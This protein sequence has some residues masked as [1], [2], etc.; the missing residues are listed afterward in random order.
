VTSLSIMR[1]IAEP[2][3]RVSGEIL[4][5]GE[6]LLK[7]NDAEIRRVRGNAIGMIYQE[8]MAALNPVL[9]IGLQIAEA[10]ELHRGASRGVA[11][12]RAAEMLRLVGISSP[13]TRLN[14]YPHQLSG[15]MRQRVMIAMALACDP[16]LLIADEPT[17]ALDVTIQAQIL[18]LIRKLRHELG[19][20]VMLITH[21]L[22]IVAEMC[23]R[24][25]VMYAGRIVEEGDVLSI[26][27]NPVHP[28][29]AALLASMPRLDLPRGRLAAIDGAVPDP[30]A[31]P[32][33]C[34]FAP[35]CVHVQ[36]RCRVESP[37]LEAIAPGRRAACFLA[38][39][40]IT[41]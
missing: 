29:T 10:V 6:D 5:E 33:G 4:F 39:D 20:A 2:P 9:P 27:T 25:V 14:E 32:R 37:P 22:G 19:M 28:Y 18:E 38:R 3:G 41:S 23:E 11:L 34:R 16:G 31:M 21:D 7:M 40:R 13:T 12:A 8:P 26:F 24:V 1:L 36:D 17:T 15:G 30:H 35:R